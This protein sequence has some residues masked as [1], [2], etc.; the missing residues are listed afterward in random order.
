MRF[1]GL[2]K[3]APIAEP[4]ATP[5]KGPNDQER[6]G[7]NA[8][9]PESHTAGARVSTEGPTGSKIADGR[10]VHAIAAT[11]VAPCQ[12]GG[13]CGYSECDQ[14]LGH[15]TPLSEARE[16]FATLEA[17]VASLTERTAG[18]EA[19][20][21]AEEQGR[22]DDANA[23]DRQREAD[24]KVT[25][26][27]R[28]RVAGLTDERDE[29]RRQ[30]ADIADRLNFAEEGA[31][32]LDDTI[33]IL[34]SQLTTRDAIIHG[35]EVSNDELTRKVALLEREARD[36]EQAAKIAH[37]TAERLEHDLAE[38]TSRAG[39]RTAQIDTRV[40]EAVE[41]ERERCMAWWY[42]FWE[43]T[44]RRNVQASRGMCDGTPAPKAG[45]TAE[46]PSSNSEETPIEYPPPGR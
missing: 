36:H 17:R 35:L 30:F 44:A 21:E 28:E 37:S 31:Q 43:D 6:E 11:P 1:G 14:D 39:E 45:G 5:A 20:L 34:E 33:G 3:D 24:F 9:G 23:A 4:A 8:S 32:Q 19:Q 10:A 18:L 12:C 46:A 2:A 7:A 26:E 22:D 42:W 16:Q 29:A 13:R 38:W 15:P 25:K 40:A 27:F 41:E